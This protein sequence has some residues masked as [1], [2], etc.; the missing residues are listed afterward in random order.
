MIYDVES[1]EESGGVVGQS[2]TSL[3]GLKGM[4]KDKAS[5]YSMDIYMTRTFCQQTVNNFDF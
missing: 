3:E 4:Q 1:Q 2:R 5:R